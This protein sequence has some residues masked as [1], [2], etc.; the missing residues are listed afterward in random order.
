MK[1]NIKSLLAMLLAVVLVLGMTPATA[2]CRPQKTN[3]RKGRSYRYFCSV[4][5]QNH[6]EMETGF[7][8]HSLQNLLQKSWHS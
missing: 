7:Q 8:R 6:S 4:L 1:R 2:S 3:S 5:Q